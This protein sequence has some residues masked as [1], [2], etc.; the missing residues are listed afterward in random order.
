MKSISINSEFA[1]ELVCAIPYAY[2]LHLRGELQSIVT[3]KGMSPFY[4]FCKEVHE[5]YEFRSLDNS[6]NGLE[7]LPNYWPHHNAH[8][9]FGR[10]YG[11]LS[12]EEQDEA[13]GVLDYNQWTPP[14]YKEYYKN[15]QF[16]NNPYIV[17][18]NNY[19]VEY[20]RDIS[21][22]LRL[23]SVNSLYKIFNYLTSRGYTVIYKRPNNTEFAPDHNEIQTLLQENSLMGHIDEL[24]EISDYDL[25]RH[26]NG[27]VVNLND[28]I[29]Q[30]NYS[31]NELQLRL[32]SNA[33]GFITTN[34]GGGILCGHF[35][36][37]VVMNI[38]D[39]KELRNNYLTNSNSYYQKISNNSLHPVFDPNNDS[40]YEKILC[41]I[42]EVF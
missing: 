16:S 13:N 7:N 24:G 38:A 27:Q 25:C 20:G 19:N 32:F 6:S 28:L 18:N 31:Y 42:K 14:P 17:L 8:A 10:N 40:D 5:A 36:S 34:G 37:P 26:Y 39:G 4:F 12:P 30:Y 22:S 23:F 11:D 1:H 15:F 35:S 33:K 41:K 29:P 2:W 9:I 21:E 3:S